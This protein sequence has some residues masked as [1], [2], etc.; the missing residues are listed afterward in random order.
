LGNLSAPAN[1]VAIFNGLC[2]VAS[3]TGYCTN[4][5]VTPIAL[6]DARFIVDP[7]IRTGLVGRNTLRAPTL[8]RFD[9][10]LTKAFGIPFTKWESDKFEIRMDFFNLFNH[11]I[12][13]WDAASVGGNS[14][15]DVFNTFFNQ[16][17]LNGGP[18]TTLR[19]F[20]S[21]RIQLRYSF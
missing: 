6:N 18:N 20:R 12:F 21:G 16:P 11:P 2:D 5:F 15:G 4:D 1:S 17:E 10:S 13:T 9:A 14:D 7:A 3:P 8:N 19:S